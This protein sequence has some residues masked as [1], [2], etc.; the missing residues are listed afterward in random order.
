MEGGVKDVRKR[1]YE[2]GFKG[3]EN[4]PKEVSIYD[5]KGSKGSKQFIDQE[6]EYGDKDYCRYVKWFRRGV[7]N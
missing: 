2:R 3:Y 6:Q 4:E 7:S 1:S 5:R